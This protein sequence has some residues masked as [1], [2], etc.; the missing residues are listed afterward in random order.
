M[1][2]VETLQNVQNTP[3]GQTVQTQSLASI[4]AANRA[5]RQQELRD[6]LLKEKVEE[7]TSK[8]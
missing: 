2:Q 3:K 7:D 1:I 5:K 4:Q 6:L 8:Y